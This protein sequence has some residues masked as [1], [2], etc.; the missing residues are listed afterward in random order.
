MNSLPL[1]NRKSQPAKPDYNLLTIRLKQM[2]LKGTEPEKCVSTLKNKGLYAQLSP[3]QLLSWSDIAMVLG[4]TDLALSILAWCNDNQ[5]QFIEAWKQHFELLQG[6][7]RNELA[8]S[9]RARA[10]IVHPEI[11]DTFAQI[12]ALQNQEHDPEVDAPFARLRQH[13][14]MLELYM[15][16]FQGR[17]DVFA[18][19]WVEKSKGTQGYM[20]VRK[21]MSQQDIC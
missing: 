1:Q 11:K 13:Q 15:D 7:G 4:E 6:L 16:Y 5:P 18:R 2:A 17:E 20:P 12:P 9:V 8:Q 19:Q 14:E 3:E 10:I 21:P